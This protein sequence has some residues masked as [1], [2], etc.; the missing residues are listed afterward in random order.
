MRTC[1]STILTMTGLALGAQAAGEFPSRLFPLEGKWQHT[2][3][4]SVQLPTDRF[5]AA[6]VNEQRIA[7][8][9]DRQVYQVDAVADGVPTKIVLLPY[10][11]ASQSGGVVTTWLKKQR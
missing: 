9:L 3:T 11:D 10:C 6:A 4:D 2:I 7:G 5:Q 1:L 8:W